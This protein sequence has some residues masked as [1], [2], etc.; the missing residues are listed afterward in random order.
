MK[1]MCFELCCVVLLVNCIH[2]HLKAGT[3]CIKKEKENVFKMSSKKG[4]VNL[5]FQ[6]GWVKLI[7]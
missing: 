6:G 4:Q 3:L 5:T 2:K 1:R 7:T